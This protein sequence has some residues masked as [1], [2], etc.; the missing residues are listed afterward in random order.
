M[1]V[2]GSLRVAS[3]HVKDLPKALLGGRHS[4][5]DT[6]VV[7]CNAVEPVGA[8]R[9]GADVNELAKRLRVSSSSALWQ[10]VWLSWTP[11]T[12]R[13]SV[14]GVVVHATRRT[15]EWSF[16][17]ALTTTWSPKQL[18]PSVS[19]TR[20]CSPSYVGT[21]STSTFRGTGEHVDE[22]SDLQRSPQG[23]RPFR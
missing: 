7:L 17:K 11:K 20:H 15:D 5:P 23:A 12:S 21:T 19:P 14:H 3:S 9:R 6:R 16:S 13:V 2:S 8:L 10:M 22:V 1:N 18:C 4:V